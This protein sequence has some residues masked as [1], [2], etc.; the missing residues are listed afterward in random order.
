MLNIVVLGGENISPKA[1]EGLILSKFDLETDVVGIPDEV[2]GEVPVAVVKPKADQE[3]STSEIHEVVVK[4]LGTGSALPRNS[5]APRHAA[6]RF[7]QNYFWKSPEE[8]AER[9]STETS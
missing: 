2:A 8:C 5:P 9:T 1:I 4:E 3:V 6:G 7:P